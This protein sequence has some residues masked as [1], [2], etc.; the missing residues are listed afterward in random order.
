ME[1]MKKLLPRVWVLFG[2]LAVVAVVVVPPVRLFAFPDQPDFTVSDIHSAFVGSESDSL[3]DG[4]VFVSHKLH[5]T[6]AVRANRDAA[7]ICHIKAL[8]KG[9]GQLGD[10]ELIGP[11]LKAGQTWQLVNNDATVFDQDVAKFDHVAI[12][13][14]AP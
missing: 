1:F 10:A 11:K 5:I 7:P 12:D 6:A 14:M 2:I 3:P 13:C 4:V 8:N 9:L